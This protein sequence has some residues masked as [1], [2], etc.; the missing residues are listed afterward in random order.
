MSRAEIRDA[1]IAALRR[2]APEVDMAR[3]QPTASLREEADLDSVDYLNFIVGLDE[4]LGVQIPESDYRRV[5][6]LDDLIEYLATRV[7][8]GRAV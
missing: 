8:T 6:T 7:V 2:V 1:V 4:R 3:L 5:A